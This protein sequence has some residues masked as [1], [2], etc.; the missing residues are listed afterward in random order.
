MQA[1]AVGPTRWS[2][3]W[4]CLSWRVNSLENIVPENLSRPLAHRRFNSIT[5][6]AAER[7]PILGSLWMGVCTGHDLV[8]SG[9]MPP[10]PQPS[11]SSQQDK[12]ICS[13][14]NASMLKVGWYSNL[15][16]FCSLAAETMLGLSFGLSSD[17][18]HILS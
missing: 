10:L 2:D 3:R 7:A 5:A 14:S 6:A 16:L 1:T 18:M 8:V 17:H 12:L 15:P 11:S 4:Q 9:C 13:H